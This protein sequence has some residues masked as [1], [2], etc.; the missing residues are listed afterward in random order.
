M[1][2]LFER[3]RMIIVEA[4][5]DLMACGEEV[6][7][8]LVQK[9]AQLRGIVL[10][11]RTRALGHWSQMSSQRMRRNIEATY[12]A[13]FDQV[14]PPIENSPDQTFRHR[15]QFTPVIARRSDERSPP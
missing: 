5:K 11:K 8:V 14:R 1:R 6:V 4:K 7:L 10:A 2:S 13:I 9:F 3:S 12:L 15:N